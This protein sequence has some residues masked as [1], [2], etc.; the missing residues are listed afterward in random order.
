MNIE[1]IRIEG[2]FGELDY[3]IKFDENKL[4]LLL[5]MV[6]AKPQSST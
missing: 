5:K 3:D 4:I 2:L 6:L 1:Q